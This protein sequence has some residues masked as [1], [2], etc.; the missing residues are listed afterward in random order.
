MIGVPIGI[1]YANIME[2]AIHKHVL[3]RIGKR[4]G[5]FWRFHF[6]DHHSS[7]RRN[8]FRDPDYEGTIFTW[9]AQGKEA[10][11]LTL[12]TLT[13]LPLLPIA[14]F[15]TATVFYSA[16]RYYRTHKRAHLDPEWGREHLPWHYDH[17]MAPD[18]E[19]NWCVTSPWFDD[20]MGTRVEYK[21]TPRE[22][23]DLDRRARRRV[24]R[25]LKRQ[26]EQQPLPQERRKAS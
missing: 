22:A 1:A 25:R 14:P 26:Q 10:L 23:R 6:H 4:R 16:V 3:H 2:W 20:I 17:H 19:C 11:T 12:S 15:F 8:D 5:S 9:N 21:D 13:H 7:S 24:R 18:Q